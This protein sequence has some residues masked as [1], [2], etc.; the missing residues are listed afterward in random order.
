MDVATQIGVEG[1]ILIVVLTNECW[2]RQCRF[3]YRFEDRRAGFGLPVDIRSPQIGESPFHMYAERDKYVPGRVSLPQDIHA[4]SRRRQ[5]RTS[6]L[7]YACRAQSCREQIL[8]ELDEVIVCQVTT[9]CRQVGTVRYTNPPL[10]R[11]GP[12]IA[13][14]GY[15]SGQ[16][17]SVAFM[18]QHT[19]PVRNTFQFIGLP[20]CGRPD[21]CLG[22][23]QAC[24][25]S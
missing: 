2:P 12:R 9:P 18:C 11:F 1:H 7:R 5:E 14:M 21:P 10:A 4:A 8:A 24:F 17:T 3:R 16:G 25:I 22:R 23:C 15:L 13:P 6:L 20:R 19:P